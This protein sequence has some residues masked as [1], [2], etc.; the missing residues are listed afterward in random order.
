MENPSYEVKLKSKTDRGKEIYNFVSADGVSGKNCFRDADLALADTVEPE[1]D[2]DILVV[3]SGYGFLPVIF[4]DQAPEGEILATETSDRAYQL[5]KLNLKENDADNATAN[6]IAFYNE[7]NQNF[8]KIV[9]APEGYEPVKVVKNRISQLIELLNDEGQLFIAGKK[10]DG[11]NRYKNY[12]NSLQGKKQKITQDGKQRV[13]RYTKTET[14][15]PESFDIET[16]FAA[17]INGIELEFTACEGLFSPN[18]LDDGSRL[19]IE[20]L[21]L[22]EGDRVLDLACGYGIIGVFVNVLYGSEIYLTDDSKT[23]THYA[24]KNL[25]SNGVQDFVLK[26][27]DCLDGF[28]DQKFDAIVSNP[29]THQGEKVTNEMF[30]QSYQS[31]RQG[32]ELYLVYNQNMRYEEKLQ[33]KF[34][35]VEILEKEDNYAVTRATK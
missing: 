5:T 15:E 16:E 10:T 18:N 14:F 19:L 9:Y 23:A 29:P 25:E 6:K 11:I 33:K 13:Y 30:N 24:E 32:G 8:D 26:N 20:N 22:S 17:E 34:S 27:R 4:A 12:L 7:I 31:L 1:L 21:E 2:E 28:K 35:K 3:Q